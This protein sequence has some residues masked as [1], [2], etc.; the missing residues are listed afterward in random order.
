M[1]WTA[2]MT[3]KISIQTLW[4]LFRQER[5]VT[6]KKENKMRPLIIGFLVSFVFLPVYIASAGQVIKLHKDADTGKVID[7]Y[8]ETKEDGTF[9]ELKEGH[10]F[11]GTNGELRKIINKGDGSF[12]DVRVGSL[13]DR[14]SQIIYYKKF[15]RLLV[16]TI[17]V[18]SIVFLIIR[19]R[20][21]LFARE[22]RNRAS[23]H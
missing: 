14:I 17:V 16:G 22:N 7:K 1:R 4:A 21:K 12:D 23:N 5:L 6:R 19:F 18:A 11:V 3:E 15:Y 8:I 20:K 13:E 2:N 10:T 9:I